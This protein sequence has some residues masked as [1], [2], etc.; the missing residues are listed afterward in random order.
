VFRGD[1]TIKNFSRPI[2]QF[3]FIFKNQK[4]NKKKKSQAIK[5]MNKKRMNKKILAGILL[6][7]HSLRSL[8]SLSKLNSF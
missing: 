4:V 3:S 8:Y 7:F 6:K 5:L 2:L 1:G